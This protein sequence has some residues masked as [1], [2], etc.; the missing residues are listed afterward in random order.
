[1]LFRSLCD[2]IKFLEQAPN[3]FKKAIQYDPNHIEAHYNL[4]V[5]YYKLGQFEEALMC[6]QKVL[7]IDKDDEQANIMK[8]LLREDKF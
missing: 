8:V 6:F 7:T 5:V 1:V 2:N 3:E 4:G